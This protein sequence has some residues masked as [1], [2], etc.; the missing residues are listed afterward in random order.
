MDANLEK[1]IKFIRKGEVVPW[2][3]SGMSLGAGYPSARGLSESIIKEAVTEHQTILER[4][5][6]NL[7]KLTGEFVEMNG[8]S[9]QTLI[10]VLRQEFRKSPTNLSTHKILVQ[11]PQ[12]KYFV[13]TNYDRAIEKAHEEVYY[14]NK[15]NV[16]VKDEDLALMD[17][18]LV[19]LYKVHG[20]VDNPNQIVITEADYTDYFRRTHSNLIWNEIKSLIPKNSVLFIGFSLEDQNIDSIFAE[21]IEHLEPIQR[22]MFLIAPNMPEYKVGKYA[23]RNIHYINMRGEEFFNILKIEIEKNIVNDVRSGFLSVKE[24]LPILQSKGLDTNFSHDK[25]GNHFLRSASISPEVASD[26]KFSGLLRANPQVLQAILNQLESGATDEIFL[27]EGEG[28]SIRTEFDGVELL[29][30]NLIKNLSLTPNPSWHGKCDLA[31][32]PSNMYIEDVDIKL[33]YNQRLV[34]LIFDVS[35]FNVK[36]IIGTEDESQNFK[37]DFNGALIPNVLRGKH[38][39][40]FFR[41]WI[42]G[43]E[44]RFFS[45]SFPFQNIP[46]IQ[47]IKLDNA[48]EALDARIELYNNLLLIQNNFQV[49]FN[50]PNELTE[51]DIKSITD[52]IN[53]S[54]GKKKR[55]EECTVELEN[56][57]SLIK[58][59]NTHS[60]S[61]KFTFSEKETIRL[62]GQEINVGFPVIDSEDFYVVDID[63]T[64]EDLQTNASV[65]LK[66]RSRS[67]N[68]YLYFEDNPPSEDK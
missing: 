27:P 56:D 34:T 24:A 40:E 57:H 36:F 42:T 46:K 38:V 2:I 60:F 61:Y 17:K 8:G 28:I 14:D 37:F 49:K 23:K 6:E 58:T 53:I 43:K 44:L 48:V 1:L 18:K 54:Y 9:R 11:V 16:V 7:Q 62:F 29:D 66:I 41:E 68:I 21:I 26:K 3:G 45:D 33:F 5:K 55:L 47:D 67:N 31:L 30:I 13:T 51:D 35:P 22:E 20:D 65:K 52:L 15:L 64:L 50:I 63:R 4:H 39:Y 12:F 19:T 59:I 10:K 25:T 32:H